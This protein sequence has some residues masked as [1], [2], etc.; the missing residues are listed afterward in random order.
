MLGLK[1]EIMRGSNLISHSNNKSSGSIKGGDIVLVP[2]ER[3]IEIGRVKRTTVGY[4][5]SWVTIEWSDGVLEDHI[6]S[7]VKK[8]EEE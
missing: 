6:V 7:K 3:G 8:V 2:E 5:Y 1:K 4:S